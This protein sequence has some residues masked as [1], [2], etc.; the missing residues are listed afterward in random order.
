MAAFAYL[1]ASAVA[2]LVVAEPE[3]AALERYCTAADGLLTSQLGAL[4]TRRAAGRAGERRVVQRVEE[5]LECFVLLDVTQHIL[6]QSASLA[7]S[8]LRTLDAMHLATALTLDLPD[9]VFV[10][11]DKRLADA[12]RAAGLVVTQPA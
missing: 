7:P 12:A 1:D 10:T 3:T 5:V 6:L 8:S 4:E 2:K 11:Y 9:L